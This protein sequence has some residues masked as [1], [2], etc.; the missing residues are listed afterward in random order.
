MTA[1]AID[2]KTSLILSLIKMANADGVVNHFEQMNI[3]I[4]SNNL[5]IDGAKI[6]MLKKNID[7]IPITVPETKKEKIEY[8][9]R[10]L[11]MMKMDLHADER[12]LVMCK[13]MGLALQF[14]E[15]ET[16]GLIAYMVDNLTSFIKLDKF[17]AYALELAQHPDAIQKSSFFEKLISIFKK[18]N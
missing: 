9:Y 12:E 13:E 14:S 7:N 4:L 15:F 18:K 8:F 11:T 6:A 10:V 1:T 2:E 3:T 5:G 16:T 17:E